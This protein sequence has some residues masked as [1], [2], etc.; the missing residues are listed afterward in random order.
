MQGQ[1]DLPSRR[2]HTVTKASRDIMVA[3][4]HARYLQIVP[5]QFFLKDGIERL[6]TDDIYLWVQEYVTMTAWV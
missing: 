5:F 6:H 2:G 4:S 1:D 3:P